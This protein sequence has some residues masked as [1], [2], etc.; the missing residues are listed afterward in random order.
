MIRRINNPRKLADLNAPAHTITQG[1][2]YLM[3][4]YI[5]VG[6]RNLET[7][8]GNIELVLVRCTMVYCIMLLSL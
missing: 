3:F 2:E 8:V 1:V 7:E 6:A 4:R 5:F